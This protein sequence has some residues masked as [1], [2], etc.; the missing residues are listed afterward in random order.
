MQDLSSLCLGQGPRKPTCLSVEFRCPTL[1]LEKTLP[2]QQASLRWTTHYLCCLPTTWKTRKQCIA[3]R[4]GRPAS[5]IF[6]LLG[7]KDSAY[8]PLKLP[9]LLCGLTP[10]SLGKVWVTEKTGRACFIGVEPAVKI[11][12]TLKSQT[13]P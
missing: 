10:C 13:L 8:I 4:Q 9:F 11:L 7:L 3:G 1:L 12:L 6:V 5:Y 2:G